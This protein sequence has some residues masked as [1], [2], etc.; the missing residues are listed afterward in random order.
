M[1]MSKQHVENAEGAV[2]LSA[3]DQPSQGGGPIPN[4]IE[5]SPRLLNLLLLVLFCILQVFCLTLFPFLAYPYALK[6][7]FVRTAPTQYGAVLLPLFLA[8][9][10][11]TA[12][13]YL[14]TAAVEGMYKNISPLSVFLL[15]LTLA[16]I[17]VF[18][19]TVWSGRFPEQR[20]DFLAIWSFAFALVAAIVSFL[21]Y[22]RLRSSDWRTIFF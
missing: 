9:L 10:M 21:E 13:S 17:G 7:D 3:H 16:P 18:G 12:L 15:G 19:Y 14:T 4:D 6:S 11:A 5:K 22:R 20:I 1:S 2:T 8:G